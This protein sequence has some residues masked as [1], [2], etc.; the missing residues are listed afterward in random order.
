VFANLPRRV[1]RDVSPRP[2]EQYDIS[3]GLV[4]TA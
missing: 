3:R 4:P 1:I 2:I